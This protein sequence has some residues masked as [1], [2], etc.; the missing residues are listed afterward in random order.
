MKMGNPSL[1]AGC[2]V[3][4][5]LENFHDLIRS[6]FRVGKYFYY[7][8]EGQNRQIKY[9]GHVDIDIENALAE[10]DAKIEKYGGV[11]GFTG[12][13]DDL[14][15]FRFY[16]DDTREMMALSFVEER[17]HH[18]IPEIM[19]AMMPYIEN[20]SY[21]QMFYPVLGEIEMYEVEDGVLM[22]HSCRIVKSGVKEKARLSYFPDGLPGDDF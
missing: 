12:H 4:F 15:V 19:T 22:W 2:N 16:Y 10:F 6:I 20:G 8:V 9:P 14:G 13:F 3:Y 21:I 5:P 17:D 7:W 18:M 1:S 11:E